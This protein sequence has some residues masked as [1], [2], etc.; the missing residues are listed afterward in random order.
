[1]KRNF[2]TVA[3]ESLSSF[4]AVTRGYWTKLQN[5]RNFFDQLAKKLNIEKQ[6]D[7]YKVSPKDIAG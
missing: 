2:S 5:Q 6:D 1:M 3:A 4:D 7:W